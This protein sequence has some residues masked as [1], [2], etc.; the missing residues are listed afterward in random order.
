MSNTLFPAGE[1]HFTEVTIDQPDYYHF[2]AN[3]G[4]Y[5]LIGPE[6]AIHDWPGLS[7]VRKQT[8]GLKYTG[9]LYYAI[10]TIN[11]LNKVIAEDQDDVFVTDVETDLPPKY[12]Q[13]D[14][15]KYDPIVDPTCYKGI[16][17][18]F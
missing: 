14:L 4:N 9:S 17:C 7:T 8:I 6:F 13:I 12:Q 11:T 18:M 15:S 10:E 1:A 2:T 16:T 5:E 3:C